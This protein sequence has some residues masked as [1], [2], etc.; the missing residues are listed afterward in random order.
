MA[1]P[2]VMSEDTMNSMIA[3]TTVRQTEEEEETSEVE[4]LLVVI[5]TG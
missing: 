1:I 3:V 2:D 4:V 5:A